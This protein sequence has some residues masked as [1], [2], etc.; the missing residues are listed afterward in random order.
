MGCDIHMYVEK[1]N[2]ESGGWEFAPA[3]EES[4]GTRSY[5]DTLYCDW[6]SGRNY[7]LFAILA[8]VRN[9]SG[10]TPISEPRGLPDNVSDG[11]L[12]EY[13]FEVLDDL[14]YEALEEKDIY[15]VE[16]YI[17]SSSSEQWLRCK[18]SQ[19]LT[20][21]DGTRLTSNPDAHSLSYLTVEDMSCGLLD[22]GYVSSNFTKLL[23][24]L[25]KLGDPR[26]VRIIFFFDN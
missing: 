5:G 26:H 14:E 3:G 20:L 16:K 25:K 7:E 17:S 13:G 15:E 18:W 11:F 12:R 22:Q 24:A 8:G 21:S 9:S 23:S 6:Y 1:K 4:P 19:L 10:L 2:L